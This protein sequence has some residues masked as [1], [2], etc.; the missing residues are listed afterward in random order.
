M[1]RTTNMCM[2]TYLCE[3]KKHREVCRKIM[4]FTWHLHSHTLSSGTYSTWIKVCIMQAF[5]FWQYSQKK[6][7]HNGEKERKRRR[8]K[9]DKIGPFLRGNVPI[10][11]ARSLSLSLASLSL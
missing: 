4:T 1:Q 10:S 11:L 2:C 8:E 7:L 5:P 9:K 3:Q 6:K